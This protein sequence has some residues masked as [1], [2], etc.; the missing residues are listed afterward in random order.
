MWAFG[1][2]KRGIWI[3]DDQVRKRLSFSMCS[4]LIAESYHQCVM[5]PSESKNRDAKGHRTDQVVLR[6]LDRRLSI[7]LSYYLYDVVR[8]TNLVW[9]QSQLSNKERPLGRSPYLFVDHN[10][11][12]YT[13]DMLSSSLKHSSIKAYGEPHGCHDHRQIGIAIRNKFFPKAYLQ[14]G[15]DITG[16]ELDE[17]EDEDEEDGVRGATAGFA[18]AANHSV[19]VDQSH[20]ALLVQTGNLSTDLLEKMR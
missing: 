16:K 9:R 4:S 10:G 15:F 18:L 14:A 2:V 1:L 6:W 19:G 12:R 8:V 17:V 20:Y 3:V 11:H 5:S 7:I 13:N